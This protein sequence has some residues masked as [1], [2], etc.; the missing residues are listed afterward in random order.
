[1][2]FYLSKVLGTL[3]TP[4]SFLV[5]L[6]VFAAVL[7]FTR[8]FRFA[9]S[10]IVAAVLALGTSTMLI[11]GQSLIA[12]LENRFPAKP[13]LP[14]SPD[15]I[16]LLGGAIDGPLSESRGQISTFDGAERY[17]EFVRL[18]QLHPRARGLV[19][20]GLGSI[21]QNA[22]GEAFHARRLLDELGIDISRISFEEESRNTDENVHYSKKLVKPKPGSLWIVITSA[23]HMPRSVGIFQRQNWPV[24]A[25]PVDYRSHGPS[26]NNQWTLFGGE[27]LDLVDTAVREWIGLVAY[28]IT[29]RTS[30]LFP[31]AVSAGNQHISLQASLAAGRPSE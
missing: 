26:G 11:T 31:R 25:W 9:R 7:L 18:M 3:L 16:I 5:L 30:A 13:E 12:P 17:F 15:G 4:T 22:K 19:S 6:M 29:D 10:L 23:Y 21:S 8:W 24:V 2:F 1:M 28:F 27:A 14:R 20:G